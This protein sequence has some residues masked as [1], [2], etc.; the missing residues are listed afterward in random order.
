M[1]KQSSGAE[2]ACRNK[3]MTGVGAQG[4]RG[5]DNGSGI[6][7][8]EHHAAHMVSLINLY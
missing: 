4:G 1:G 5:Q 8:I 6:S 3:E 2:A 7:N